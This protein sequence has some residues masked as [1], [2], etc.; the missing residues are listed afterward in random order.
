MRTHTRRRIRLLGAGVVALSLVAAACGDDDDDDDA[1]PDATAEPAATAAV[2]APPADT[3]AGETTGA[4]AGTTEG[5]TAGEGT[6]ADTTEADSTEPDT[7]EA[8]TTDGTTDGTGAGG[9]GGAVTADDLLGAL[10]APDCA[11]PEAVSLQLQWA[12]QAQFA[13][14][15][16]ARD[17]G[18]YEAMCLDVELIET[19]VDVVPQQQLADGAVDFAIA[20]V[21]KALQTR[22]QGADIVNIAQ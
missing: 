22:E 16:A 19:G 15:M 6:E 5:T 3:A 8:D 18:F 2:T 21:P 20:W 17:L 11:A 14:Y 1:S 7:T 12:Y 9:A 13:G 4:A 10:E